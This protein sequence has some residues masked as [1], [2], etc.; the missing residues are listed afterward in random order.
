LAISQTSVDLL[1]QYKNFTGLKNWLIRVIENENF[2]P[3]SI[4]VVYTSDEYLLSVNR[5]FLRRNYYTD[6]ISFNYSEGKYI[7]GDIL[8]SIER[9]SDNSRKYGIGFYDETDRV[10]LHGLLHLIG[11]NDSGLEEKKKMR[12]KESYYLKRR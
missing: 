2:I 5:K 6:V 9:I 8:I 12:E 10:I 11:Y 4:T 1:F 3:G 7:S